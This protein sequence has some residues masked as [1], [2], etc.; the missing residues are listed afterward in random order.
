M[1]IAIDLG[2]GCP[3]DGGA[4]GIAREEDFIDRTGNLLIEKLK[5]SHQIILTRPLK[6]ISTRDSL[7][8]RC[9]IANNHKCE[10]FVSIHFNSF[11]PRANGVETFAISKN[12]WK[13][14]TEICQNIAQLGYSYRGVKQGRHLYVLRNTLMPAILVEGCFISNVNDVALFDEQK[15]SDA[16]VEGLE[17]AYSASG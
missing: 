13:Y 9:E 1:K 8:Q 16:I 4:V 11:T 15:M 2:H 5:K 6:T 12:G 10:L 14:A 7:K 3:F 17:R